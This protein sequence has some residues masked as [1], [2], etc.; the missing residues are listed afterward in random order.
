MS[1]V[2]TKKAA[3]DF[4]RYAN[5][6]ED[7]H[8]LLSGLNVNKDAKLLSIASAGD[9]TLSLL[10]LDPK[11]VVAVDINP[12][13]LYLTELKMR[14]IQCLD[15]EA[16]LAFLGFRACENRKET[17]QKVRSHLSEE[18]RQYFDQTIDNW[19]HQGIIHTGKFEKY[20]QLFKRR[21]LPLIHSQKTVK[22]LLAEKSEV[23]QSAFY[24]KKWN[25]WRWRGLVKFF[26]SSAVMGKLG[27]DPAFF[28]EVKINV[29]E[30]ILRKSAQQF[31]SKNSQ[32]NPFLRYILT[33]SFGDTLPHYLH[34]QNYPI[35]KSQIHKIVLFQGFAEDAIE[36][37][38]PFN[39]MNLSNI[40]EYMDR[41]LFEETATKLCEGLCPG[42]KMVYWNL[43]VPRRMSQI[44]PSLKED[45]DTIYHLNKSDHGF[46]YNSIVV[47]QKNIAE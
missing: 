36:T 37:H 40:F 30:Y 42:G 5:V 13:Q 21:I 43:M 1:E 44:C 23:E 22:Q 24:Q 41:T 14:S 12:V 45:S 35:V 8:S 25:N 9:N 34:E 39:G 32:H 4:I 47:D 7:A 3:F 6:W 29:S 15:R 16:T 2:I 20:F 17:Y 26:F 46:F 19:A 11:M 31:E 38:G 33:G 18:A 27:R 28:N 10:T